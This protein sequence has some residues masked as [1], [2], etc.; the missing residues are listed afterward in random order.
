MPKFDYIII[1]A[2]ASG[3]MLAHR[4]VQDDH[5]RDRSILLLDKSDKSIN[6]RTWCFWEKGEGRFDHLIHKTWPLIHF[7]GRHLHKTTDIAP[8]QYK[9]IRGLDFYEYHLEQLKAYPNISFEIDEVDSLVETEDRVE[10]KGAMGTYEGQAVFTSILDRKVMFAQKRFPVLQQHFIGWFIKTEKP[11]FDV[12]AARFMDFSIP[13]KGNTRFMYV[14]PFSETHALIE[15]TLFSADLLETHE[16]ESAI[17]DYI[18]THFGP[19]TYEI[20]EKERGNIPMTCYEFEKHNSKRIAHLGIAGG[21]AKPSTGYT[22]HR[23]MSRVD[24][25]VAFT[26]TGKPFTAFSNKNKFWY[27][28]LLLLDVLYQDNALGRQV[29]EAMFEKRSPQSIFKFLDDETSL[30]E[31]FLMINSCPKWPFTKALIKRLF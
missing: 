11:I 13:Q 5:F 14:L 16:Y 25:L 6:D 19:I 4:M 24:K 2:G 12:K 26:K 27:Y 17:T 23:S 30:R 15:Y 28:D 21:W 20:V 29:F 7:A 3:L 10:V 9:M 8:Y 31:D 18:E 1:G 22:F